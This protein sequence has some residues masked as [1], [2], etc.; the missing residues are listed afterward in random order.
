MSNSSQFPFC[1]D[2]RAGLAS[3]SGPFVLALEALEM[4]GDE[5]GFTDPVVI[6]GD[7][8]GVGGGKIEG[9]RNL[10]VLG[11]QFQG[12]HLQRQGRFQPRLKEAGRRLRL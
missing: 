8:R 10:G 7:L 2:C 4:A 9:R 5:S 6:R 12:T 1:L 3:D 11:L